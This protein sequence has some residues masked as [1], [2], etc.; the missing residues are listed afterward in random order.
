MNE[1]RLRRLES[2]LILAGMV[3]ESPDLFV[4]QQNGRLLTNSEADTALASAVV[5]EEMLAMGF[6]FNGFS[7]FSR[8]IYTPNRC[9]PRIIFSNNKA[10][11]TIT[12]PTSTYVVIPE[13]NTG[14]T[15]QH[16][17]YGFADKHDGNVVK[18][19]SIPQQAIGRQ[20][21]DLVM[22]DPKKEFNRV[23]QRVEF[24]QNAQAPTAILE[25]A[26][27]PQDSSD[28]HGIAHDATRVAIS[29]QGKKVPDSKARAFVSVLSGPLIV[30]VFRSVSSNGQ[31]R[32]QHL[33]MPGTNSSVVV[34]TQLSTEELAGAVRG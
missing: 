23:R 34:Y 8:K 29:A 32:Y 26:M 4:K 19:S 13:E 20:E 18:P 1:L 30:Q 16:K 31:W 7:L 2:G 28:G 33:L 3:R 12:F 24:D 6:D 10:T 21:V 9:V 15:S 22:D 27:R 5:L 25:N 14:F 11:D 17:V